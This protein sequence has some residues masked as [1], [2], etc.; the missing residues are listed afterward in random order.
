MKNKLLY[1]EYSGDVGLDRW[2]ANYFIENGEIEKGVMIDIGAYHP[3]YLNNSYFFE[4]NGWDTYC[5][6]ANPKMIEELKKVRKNVI[7]YA[8]SDANED[9]CDFIIVN[10]KWDKFGQAGGTGFHSDINRTDAISEVIKVR[11]ITLDR[12][13][14]TEIKVDKIDVISMDVE[15]HELHI[16]NG[17]DIARWKPK[18]MIIENFSED[19]V[20]ERFQSIRKRLFDNGYELSARIAQN[21]CFVIK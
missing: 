20:K 2:I 7:P 4:K 16:L 13:L 12:L 15:G 10:G 8:V 5:I 6:E 1:N 11:K 9:N 14:E 21:D 17:F 19:S 18:I 3:T